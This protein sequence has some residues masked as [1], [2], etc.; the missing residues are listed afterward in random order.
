MTPPTNK[1]RV[2]TATMQDY[3]KELLR[4]EKSHSPVSTSTLA[5]ALNVTPSAVTAMSCKLHVAG[6]VRYA[7]Y[8]GMALT[9]A[10]QHEARR[11]LRAH[12]LVEV[13]MVRWMGYGWEEVDAEAERLE[14]ALSPDFIDRLDAQLGYPAACPHGDP[15]PSADGYLPD[16]IETPLRGL[17]PGAHGVVSRVGT[18]NREMLVYLRELGLTPDAPVEVVAV[19]PFDGPLTIRIGETEHAV[20]ATVAENVFV[21]QSASSVSKNS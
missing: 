13:M 21:T 7:A 14:H 17:A 19:A 18:R 20:S 5:E 8:Q 11:V 1:L 12:R 2:A 4:L 9:P 16:I 10:G 6:L 3:L 15:I